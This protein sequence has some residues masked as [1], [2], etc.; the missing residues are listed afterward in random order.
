[1]APITAVPCH[2][3]SE[4]AA[5]LAELG[6]EAGFQEMLEHALKVVPDLLRVEVTL[7]PPYEDDDEDR[8]VMNAWVSYRQGDAPNPGQALF[9]KW[10]VE[11][12]SPDIWRHVVLLVWHEAAE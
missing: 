6:I 9:R 12:I 1:M 10:V 4:A 2:V 8:V 7:E 3:S 11:S 5:H